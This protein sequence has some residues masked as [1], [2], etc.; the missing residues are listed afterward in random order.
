V[1][2]QPCEECGRDD[3]QARQRKTAWMWVSCQSWF[4][5]GCLVV[6]KMEVRRA[7]KGIPYLVVGEE[8][9]P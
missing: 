2:R 4:P 8:R 9:L 6:A 3:C 7:R 1:K 5:R